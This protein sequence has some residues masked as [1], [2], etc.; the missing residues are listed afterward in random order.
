M[1]QKWINTGT[2]PGYF[3]AADNWDP[4][5]DPVT[6]A[7]LEFDNSDTSLPLYDPP[8]S[9]EVYDITI[10]NIGGY[11]PWSGYYP[12]QFVDPDYM[13]VWSWNCLTIGDSTH[14]SDSVC[15][16]ADYGD[17]A[18]SPSIVV[19]GILE[20]EGYLYYS[21]LVVKPYG[22]AHI[23]SEYGAVS[24]G[25]AIEALGTVAFYSGGYLYL[26]HAT[27]PL[28]LSGTL[29]LT[30]GYGLECP[31]API[32][33]TANGAAMNWGGQYVSGGFDAKPAATQFS[34][35]HTCPAGSTL[36]C[37]VPGNLN[38][39]GA[40]PELMVFVC[41][42]AEQTVTL[43][44]DIS[45]LG[46]SVADVG[47]L[48]LN[49]KVV[50]TG[51]SGF[52]Q[53]AGVVSGAWTFVCGGPFSLTGGTFSPTGPLA[54]TM[55]AG[56]FLV[57][58]GATVTIRID[59]T[60]GAG[61]LAGGG[62]SGAGTV[63]AIVP[64]GV[65][66]AQFYWSS[67]THPLDSLTVN[68]GATATQSGG[69]NVRAM[70]VNGTLNTVSHALVLHPTADEFLV[71][72]ASGVIT[73][74]GGDMKIY[75]T[76]ASV[77]NANVVRTSTNISDSY[78]YGEPAGSARTLTCNVFRTLSST[79]RGDLAINNLGAAAGMAL[80]TV[81]VESL[82][83]EDIYLGNSTAGTAGAIVMGA[84]KHTFKGVGVSGTS[85]SNSITFGGSCSFSGTITLPKRAA[86]GAASLLATGNPT[87]NGANAT[88][89][90][91]ST[92]AHV[93]G[94]V[95]TNLAL[96]AAN[97]L[98]RFGSSGSDTGNGAGVIKCPA[99]ASGSCVP[100]AA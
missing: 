73:G 87:I 80:A 13:G 55:G 30:D 98:Y 26:D 67:A 46:L 89:S 86:L 48:D 85:T 35:T 39:G 17:G 3:H 52:A 16:D 71:Y 14:Y 25:V 95:V 44:D 47:T 66:M 68:V 64:A 53:S 92:G 8:V 62:L 97:P 69:L 90:L 9:G 27:D 75:L 63:H 38:L 45:V 12:Q 20:L 79:N 5:Y 78:V 91:T 51:A 100:M 23:T 70:T 2:D 50:T 59:V 57:T 99:P 10:R 37:D 65:T 72:G 28:L 18:G 49:G 84:G 81:V 40:A 77:S 6:G 4:A 88:T 34:V 58:S 11:G 93:H 74:N 60:V 32:K 94:G 33:A 29:D 19:H 41:A 54:L 83:A 15:I 7:A 31:T 96:T 36:Y 61:G 21:S 22:T 43:G 76:T 42:G 82:S 56:L 24:A 1:T